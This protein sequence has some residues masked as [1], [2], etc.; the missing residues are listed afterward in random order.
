VIRRRAGR[1]PHLPDGRA[2]E[3]LHDTLDAADPLAPLRAQFD[4]PPGLI[5]L[6]GNSLGPPVRGASERVRRVVEAEWGRGLIAS[7][8]EAKWIDAPFTSGDRIGR[9]I[10]AAPGQVVAGD[11]TS[12]AL[13]KVLAAALSLRPGRRTI[14]S[15]AGNFPTDLYVAEG[16]AALAGGI[17]LR[18]A[19]RDGPLDALLGP[20]VAAVMLTEVDFRTGARHDMAAVTQ[21][22]HACGAL[23]IWDLAHSAG[24]FE[25]ALD[26]AGADFAVGCTY[27]YLNAGPGAPAYLYAAARHHEAARQPLTGWLGHADPFAFETGYRPASGIARFVTGTPPILAFAPLFASLDVWDTID[28]RQVRAKSLAL[29]DLFITRVDRFAERHGLTLATPRTHAA[30]G[31]QV[32][33]RH[34]AG[35]AI[36]KALIAEGVVGDFRSPDILR[37]GFT[38]STLSFAEVAEA[39]ARLEAI[40]DDGRWRSFSNARDAKVT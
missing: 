5:Y 37:F 13:F 33:L 14:V 39:A 32:S 9:L 40:L 1:V 23:A 27:K 19:G 24:A 3:R 28:M 2:H 15:E 17:S 11:S 6:D 10:G 7:W 36:V 30:R 31:S 34:P 4:L 18:L 35:Y 20:D 16:L 22:I 29:T 12:V 8:N 26:A 38:P 21:R 25:V